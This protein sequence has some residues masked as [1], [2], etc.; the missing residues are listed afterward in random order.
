LCKYARSQAA[1]VMASIATRGALRGNRP[2]GWLALTEAE[3]V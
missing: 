1:D 2:G 3:R